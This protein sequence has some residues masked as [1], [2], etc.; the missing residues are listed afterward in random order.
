MMK[1]PELLLPAGTPEALK[2]AILYGAD[3]V[4]AGVPSLSLRAKT[5]FD[6]GTLADA[7]K[8]THDLGKKIYL[9]LNLF[10]KND[11]AERLDEFAALIGRL[12]PDGLI[13]SDPGVFVFMREKVNSGLF[14]GIL[15]GFCYVGSTIS[16][17]GLGLVADNFRWITVFWILIG[18]CFFAGIVWCIYICVRYILC[19]RERQLL[20]K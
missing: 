8:E 2:T 4:Y 12:A 14:A 16:S 19:V 9:T 15:N 5:A 10:S 17:Y 6:E 18:C 20:T 3:A 7:I 1:K 13:V 11:D